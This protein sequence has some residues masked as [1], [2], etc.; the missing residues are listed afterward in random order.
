MDP[1][2]FLSITSENALTFN[3]DDHQGV[4]VCTKGF[5][6]EQCNFPLVL[7]FASRFTTATGISASG[8]IVAEMKTGSEKNVKIEIDGIPCDG[9]WQFFI[10]QTLIGKEMQYG[11]GDRDDKFLNAAYYLNSTELN[12]LDDSY[13]SELVEIATLALNGNAV[14]RGRL[15]RRGGD[16]V[17]GRQSAP[18]SKP[19][20]APVRR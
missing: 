13:N 20:A 3:D 1:F 11:S 10:R 12:A 17:H 4:E 16:A 14:R 19:A 5:P 18:M 7:E 2:E 15:H 6:V 9:E 8:D